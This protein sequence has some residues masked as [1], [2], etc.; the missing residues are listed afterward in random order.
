MEVQRIPLLVSSCRC[1]CFFKSLLVWLLCASK[2]S[3]LWRGNSGPAWPG[4]ITNMTCVD[5]NSASSFC[6]ADSLQYVSTQ[7]VPVVIQYFWH[8]YETPTCL[9]TYFAVILSCVHTDP[10]STP[11]FAEECKVQNWSLDSYH[12][13]QDNGNVTMYL[14]LAYHRW[15]S[16]KAMN[17]LTLL[18]H[19]LLQASAGSAALC[20]Q[21]TSLWQWQSVLIAD[22]RDH[23]AVSA[24]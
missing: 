22:L 19:L 21:S 20:Q 24:T 9:P 7:P 1:T 14:R 11:S 6:T 17:Q 13:K 5:L 16:H 10:S 4:S 12:K 3:N 18:L 8:A 23:T 15:T 2:I